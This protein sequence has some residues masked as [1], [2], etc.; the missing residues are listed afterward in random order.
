LLKQYNERKFDHQTRDIE[1]FNAE[2]G[3]LI[4][5]IKQVDNKAH[6][7][8][9]INKLRYIVELLHK[10]KAP[11]NTTTQSLLF[12]YAVLTS[13][14]DYANQLIKQLASSDSDKPFSTIDSVVQQSFFR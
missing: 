7:K 13:N 1:A 5:H 14:T 3:L 10:N 9:F 8:E 4:S 6:K 2:L 12:E 11:Q